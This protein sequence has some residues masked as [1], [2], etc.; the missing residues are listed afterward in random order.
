MVDLYLADSRILCFWN[1]LESIHKFIVALQVLQCLF[2]M[3]SNKKQRKGRII[4][5][6][7]KGETFS[8]LMTSAFGGNLTMWHPPS[9]PSFLHSSKKTFISPS[10]WPRREY[11]WHSVEKRA[12]WFILKIARM[13]SIP[14]SRN[15][16]MN[17]FIIVDITPTCN[18]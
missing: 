2:V 6:F 16:M 9:P 7:T 3:V 15:R 17:T 11:T 5:N 10:V 4:S 14:T 18:R 1:V 12:Y 13:F 8:S